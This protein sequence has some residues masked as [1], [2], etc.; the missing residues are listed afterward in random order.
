MVLLALRSTTVLGTHGVFDTIFVGW[1]WSSASFDRGWTRQ[2][3]TSSTQ[4]RQL[5]KILGTELR[6]SAQGFP[7]WDTPPILFG[8]RQSSVSVLEQEPVWERH[9]SKR[10]RCGTCS[11]Y[12]VTAAP[13]RRSIKASRQQSRRPNSAGGLP[14]VG[15]GEVNRGTWSPIPPSMT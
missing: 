2:L 7:F 4:Q 8:I 9:D 11:L 5:R 14:I 10:L 13:C 1:I 12:M 15:V 6:R 3:R